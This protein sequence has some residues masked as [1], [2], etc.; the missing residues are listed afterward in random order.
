MRCFAF[1]E[2]HTFSGLEDRTDER[3]DEHCEFLVS[4]DSKYNFNSLDFFRELANRRTDRW[5][6]MWIVAEIFLSKKRVKTIID[7]F[8][9]TFIV[10]HS[11]NKELT[12]N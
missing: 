12:N 4:V 8:C 6:D 5:R 1:T 9:D 7:L 3:T 10:L 2:V 11:L